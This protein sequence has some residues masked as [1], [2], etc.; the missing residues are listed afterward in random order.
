MVGRLHRN[1]L[2]RDRH[3]LMLEPETQYGGEDS[4]ATQPLRGTPFSTFTA[5][6][7]VRRYNVTP[8]RKEVEK[9]KDTTHTVSPSLVCFHIEPTLCEVASC[10]KDGK[11]K[12]CDKELVQTPK[13]ELGV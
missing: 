10:L 13:I 9:S 12:S 1:E 8:F 7:K 6:S 2:S 4:N 3:M 5:T 11:T